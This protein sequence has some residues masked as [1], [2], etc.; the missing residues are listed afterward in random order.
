MKSQHSPADK[1]L[2]VPMSPWDVDSSTELHNKATL[3][4]HLP[5]NKFV[6][7]AKDGLLLD[8]GLNHA[9]TRVIGV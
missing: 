7:K 6:N 3:P 9:R 8:G 2:I 5:D 4:L 1:Y